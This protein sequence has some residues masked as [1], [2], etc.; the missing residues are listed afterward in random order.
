MAIHTELPIYKLTYELMR[1]AMELIK[2]MRRDYKGTVG[3]EINAEC[4]GLTV[5]VY[6]AN[7][8]RD[9]SPYLDKLLE[10][11]QVV[12]L[13]FRLC[14]DLQLISVGQYAKAIALTNKIG[15]QANGWRK[16]S[17]SRPAT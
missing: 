12:E 13:L 1:M 5:L 2:N 15:R 7:C 11:V 6:R 14:S 8:A 9:K 3:K 10:R 16:S 4:L 17:A